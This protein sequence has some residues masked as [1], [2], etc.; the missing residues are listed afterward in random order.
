MKKVPFASQKSVL[1]ILCP[2]YFVLDA[3]HLMNFFNQP[4]FPFLQLL[5]HRRLV[6]DD[7]RGVEE[8]L[9]ETTGGMSH[10][11]DW[12]R[13]GD[14]ITVTG[15]CPLCDCDFV[16]VL[17]VIS[18]LGEVLGVDARIENAAVNTLCS[19]HDSF[20]VFV[21]PFCS[22]RQALLALVER[23]GRPEG[24][25]HVDGRAVPA[26]G[27]LVLRRAKHLE[28]LRVPCHRRRRRCGQC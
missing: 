25:A 18:L 1:L 7:N 6:V 16:C 24:S 22:F 11:P 20:V 2:V 4:F 9:N 17:A 5:I 21:R 10:Y 12:I 15:T 14:G 19:V 26:S 13:S 8:A 3:C 28:A 27:A 23:L